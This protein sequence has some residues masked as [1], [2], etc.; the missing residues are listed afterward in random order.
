MA[1]RGRAVKDD[2]G[3]LVEKN[4]WGEI[5]WTEDAFEGGKD[6]EIFKNLPKY[7]INTPMVNGFITTPFSKAVQLGNVDNVK[8]LL[9]TMEHDDTAKQLSLNPNEH[10]TPPLYIAAA[11]NNS[12]EMIKCLVDAGSRV[13]QTNEEVSGMTPLRQALDATSCPLVY[14]TPE[15]RRTKIKIIKYLLDNGADINHLRTDRAP[16]NPNAKRWAE[17]IRT[18]EDPDWQILRYW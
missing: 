3:G 8:A 9:Q 7:N 4:E 1:A 2:G 11:V 6:I 15:A 16:I 17:S 14:L 5:E 18:G 10:A 13:E 12:F